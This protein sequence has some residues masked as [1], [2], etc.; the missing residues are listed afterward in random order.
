MPLCSS[1]VFTSRGRAV[2][3]TRLVTLYVCVRPAHF[4]H[5]DPFP[6]IVALNSA[7]CVGRSDATISLINYS[8]VHLRVSVME[9]RTT[10]L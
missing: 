4:N 1:A 10:F 6:Q 8:N 9:R 3:R 2:K 5:L 7:V